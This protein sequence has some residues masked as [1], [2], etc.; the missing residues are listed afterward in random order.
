MRVPPIV[1]DEGDTR[2]V[3]P[4]ETTS[5]RP[6]VTE[7]PGRIA[8]AA[9]FVYAVTAASYRS[10]SATCAWIAGISLRP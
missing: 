8:V 9:A 1:F 4:P 7:M 2:A 5:P 3:T 6:S 10:S